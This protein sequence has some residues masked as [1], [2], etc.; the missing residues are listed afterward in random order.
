VP[1]TV[2]AKQVKLGDLISERTHILVPP[3]QRSYA[4]EAD[5]VE[6]FIS[7]ILQLFA[8]RLS[9]IENK[10]TSDDESNHFLGGLVLVE[11]PTSTTIKGKA[12]ELVDGQ[13]RL[14]TL[15]LALSKIVQA[16]KSLSKSAQKKEPLTASTALFYSQQT[17][18]DFLYYK[19]MEGSETVQSPRL[20]LSS[21]DD[22]FFTSLL[23][24]ERAPTASKNAPASHKRLARA[25]KMLSQKLIGSIAKNGGNTP[26]EVLRRLQV[27]LE[28]LTERLWVVKI[29]S[30]QRMEAYSL[31]STLNDRGRALNEGDLLRVRSLQLL[32]NFPQL[33]DQLETY[34]DNV[35]AEER[36][37]VQTFL[38]TYYPS[39]TGVRAPRHDLFTRFSRHFFP[40]SVDSLQENQT[41]EAQKIVSVVENIHDESDRFV[42]ISEGQW[43]YP[44][45]NVLAWDRTRLELLIRALRNTL[46]I[47]LLLAARACLSETDFAEVVHIIDLFTFRSI[48][49][50]KLH[51]GEASA[52]YYEAAKLIRSEP[53]SFE[54]LSFRNKLRELLL[55]EEGEE[56]IFR[57]RLTSLRYD[58]GPQER[59]IMMYLLTT[60]ESYVDWWN[61]ARTFPVEPNKERAYD[62]N[63]VRVDYIIP[64]DES[65]DPD[66]ADLL[67]SIGN[68]VF[69]EQSFEG[70]HTHESIDR[71][72]FFDQSEVRLTSALS[73]KRSL[74]YK[75]VE[76]RQTDLINMAVAVFALHES[77]Y[78]Q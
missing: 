10:K 55:S 64:P 3:Y 17:A 5:D 77:D 37:D 76:T 7:D 23:L 58:K 41:L 67:Q 44:E 28:C 35:L 24:A 73:K 61:G 29:V 52:I 59:R 54:V 39:Y 49:M 33:Q 30:T 40:F 62:I 69:F 11:H 34:W 32:A 6:D 56:E 66:H 70:T 12:Y 51:V 36:S 14:A 63:Q 19:R 1:N 18:D 4:W 9:D 68:L 25:S 72:A 43:P 65:T 31:F 48:N 47:P 13:Q 74:T 71:H 78:S 16:F 42:D 21:V 45:S 38:R 22:E 75:T 53:D 27:L 60:L 26:S 15:A 8:H 20:R 2:D 50:D 57:T 46:A